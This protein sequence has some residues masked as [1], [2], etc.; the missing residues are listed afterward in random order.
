[1]TETIDLGKRDFNPEE[2]NNPEPESS[3]DEPIAEPLTE[4][5]QVEQ[6]KEK[7]TE[8][9]KQLYARLKEAESK[10]KGQPKGSQETDPFSLARTV[11][12]L[13]DYDVREL[14]FA[15]LVSKAKGIRPEDAVQTEE[16]KTFLEGKRAL[17][18]KNNSIPRPNSSASSS[19]VK[20]PEDIAA[21]TDK[22][23]QQYE[24]DFRGRQQGRG[25]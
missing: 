5:K 19:N 2:L 16:F 15:S 25:I 8:R 7:Y 23:F 14:D 11:A 3:Q 12:S 10:L 13:K 9:E 22:E 20:S 21:M 1:M 6:P 24:K 18:I 17:D 4:D